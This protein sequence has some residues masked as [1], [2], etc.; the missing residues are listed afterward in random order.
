MY[1]LH[2][3]TFRTLKSLLPGL[4]V[5]LGGVAG[6][7]ACG[8]QDLFSE[9]PAS[10]ANVKA[11][12]GVMNATVRLS[13]GGATPFVADEVV[14]SVG[15]SA[16][17]R[18]LVI[19]AQSSDLNETLAFVIDLSAAVFPGTVDLSQHGVL[20]VEPGAGLGGGDLTFDGLP[21]GALELEGFPQPGTSVTGRFTVT[22]PGYDPARTTDDVSVQIDGT[23]MAQV[24]AHPS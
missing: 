9:I 15:P 22:L 14:A 23:F 4:F 5:S 2:L 1:P 10:V 20:Y 24:V 17:G 21:S 7:T 16:R 3:N 13:G 8:G 18:E 19:Y 6:L 12:E 11:G